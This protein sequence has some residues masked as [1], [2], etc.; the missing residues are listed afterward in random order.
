MISFAYPYGCHHEAARACA[1]HGFPLAFTTDEG[2]NHLETNPHLLRRTM[3]QPD[4]TP[5][6]LA[7]RLKLGYSPLHHL[8][9]RLR[10]RTRF[11]RAW[12][13]IVTG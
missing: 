3:V 12:H 6:V 8:R 10:I 2:L 5:A 9:A 11:K 13:S 4:D 7:C 1:G